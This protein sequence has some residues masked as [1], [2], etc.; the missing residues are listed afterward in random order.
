MTIWNPWHGCIKIS[1]G[2]NHCYVYS[3]DAEFG[4][5]TTKVRK[6]SKFDLPI[7]KKKKKEY[8]LMPEEEPVYTCE[9]EEHVHG[10]GCS[11][12]EGNTICEMPEHEHVDECLIEPEEEPKDGDIIESNSRMFEAMVTEH[13]GIPT[14]FA[15]TADDYELLK[16][17]S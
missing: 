13:G 4:K 17:N 1:P 14:R 10:E 8:K 5:D 12:A 7:Q 9:L 11:D 15:P 6:T 3:K 2:C 16:Q